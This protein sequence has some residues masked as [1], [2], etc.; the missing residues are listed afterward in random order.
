MNNLFTLQISKPCPQNFKTLKP[1]STGG[2][3]GNCKKN[4]IDFTTMSLKQI[5]NYFKLN[6]N[7]NTCGRFNTYQLRT[8]ANNT[9]SVKKNSVIGKLSLVILSLFCLQAFQAQETKTSTEFKKHKPRKTP[10]KTPD[11]SLTIGGTVNDETGPLPGVSILLQGTIN[12]T[13][14]DFNGHFKFPKKL[15]KGDVLLFSY[16]GMT[17][18]KLVIDPKHSNL[19]VSM[20]TDTCMLMGKVAVKNIYRSKKSIWK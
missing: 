7:S 16:I 10:F 20:V 11:N 17:S 6:T 19:K 3:C 12:G 9:Q 4:V 2:F 18:Q 14:T 5:T 8:Y 1:T 13:E 15:T